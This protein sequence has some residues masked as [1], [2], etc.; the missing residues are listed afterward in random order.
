MSGSTGGFSVTITAK[1]GASKTIDDINKRLDA[2]AKKMAAT[3]A[4]GAKVG[5]DTSGLT[6][7]T[8]G[9]KS[10]A[11]SSADFYRSLDKIVPAMSALTGATTLAGMAA[12]TR[13]FAE[14]GQSTS[15]IAYQLNTPVEK[16]GA[17]RGAVRLVGVSTSALESS[18]AGLQKTMGDAAWERSGTAVAAFKQLGV[19]P[20]SAAQHRFRQ[21][22]DVLGDVAEAIKGMDAPTQARTL[23]SLGI[24][25]E[26]LPALKNGR[27]AFEDLQN[28]ALKTGGVMS[29]DMVKHAEDMNHAWVN[30]SET[31]EG[32]GNRLVDHYAPKVTEIL[33]R[34][35]TWIQ[36]NQDLADSIAK[37][38]IAVTGL[39]AIKPALWVLRLLGLANPVTGAIVG[40]AAGAAAAYETGAKGARAADLGFEP[41]ATPGSMDEFGNVFSWT[42]P[43]TGETLTAAEMD[44]RLEEQKERI[45]KIE[46]ERQ[47]TPGPQS[48]NAGPGTRQLA[49]NDS[50]MPQM[51]GE[52]GPGGRTYQ[53][54]DPKDWYHPGGSTAAQGGQITGDT[55]ADSA[56][57]KAEFTRKMMPLAEAASAQTGVDARIIFAQAALE[58]G[59]G[60]RAPQNNYFGIKGKGAFLMTKEFINGRMVDVPQSFAGYGSMEGSV[61]GYADLIK[62]SRRYTAFRTARGVDAQI[63]ELDR[64]GYYTDPNYKA[65]L[66]TVV[67]SLPAPG[68]PAL[69]FQPPPT[70]A[71]GGRQ[72]GGGQA[73][74]VRVDVNLRGAPPGTSAQVDTRGAVR[75]APP[76]IETAM[77]AGVA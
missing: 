51:S 43:K 21:V 31:I 1:D 57:S 45:D 53:Q 68:P 27:K 38:G 41:S 67:S 24:S 77:S 73:G 64:S 15:N 61:Q 36:N 72:N 25:T 59:W 70:G 46:R 19:D 30:L 34:T 17:L 32:V 11:T 9:F 29:K 76:R 48:S 60:R 16:L 65:K 33:K 5:A 14:L 8:E 22:A 69:A 63:D 26:M 58:S 71:A 18:M 55:Q 49:S 35:S 20:G 2:M 40:T 13:R 7:L 56:I 12:L 42:N 62:N 44:K 54:W 23:E 52:T 66:R 75:A 39:V 47:G 28:E 6:R 37:I 4:Q 3:S 50:S 10:T 74:H